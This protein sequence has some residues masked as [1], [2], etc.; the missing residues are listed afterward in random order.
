MFLIGY[1]NHA[2]KKYVR[3]NTEEHLERFSPHLFEFRLFVLLI[4]STAE[5]GSTAVLFLFHLQNRFKS[6]GQVGN[7]NKL[8]DRIRMII[9]P[10]V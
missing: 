6:T 3:E 8:I 1:Q 10:E 9:N 7:T 4:R 2:D 5:H